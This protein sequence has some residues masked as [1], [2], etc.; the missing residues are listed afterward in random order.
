MKLAKPFGHDFLI[1]LDGL[2]KRYGIRPSAFLK[3][4]IKDFLIDVAAAIEGI[5]YEEKQM[6]K[7]K[8]RA[9]HKN[10]R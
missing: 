7:T 3:G 2:A 6:K 1:T 9:T 4:S 10:I 5:K 8:A